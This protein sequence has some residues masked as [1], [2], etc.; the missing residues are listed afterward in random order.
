MNNEDLN[1]PDEGTGER[2]EVANPENLDAPADLTS[3]GGTQSEATP[4]G[5]AVNLPLLPGHVKTKRPTEAGDWLSGIQWLCSTVVLAIFVI[6]FI[7]QA[8]QIPSESMENTLLIG[9]YLLVDKVHY[10]EGSAW[11]WLMPYTPIR[12]GD[13]VVFRYPVHPA[14]HFVKRVVGIPGDRVHLFRGTVFVNGKAI[15]DSRFAIHKAA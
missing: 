14:Q 15:D 3:A 7:V 9:D 13:I 2:L 11:N 6:T 8:F 1:L 12:R 10:G 4:V 5:D